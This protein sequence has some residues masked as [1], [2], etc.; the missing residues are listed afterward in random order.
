MLRDLGIV[1][2]LHEEVE[3]LRL[4]HDEKL[5]QK[6]AAQKM[7]ISQT[8]IHRTLESAYKKVTHA[9]LKGHALRI[10]AE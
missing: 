9:L 5:D 10:E 7:G 1:D 2:L 3:A 4:V 6:S 8:T